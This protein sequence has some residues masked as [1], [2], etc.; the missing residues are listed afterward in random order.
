MRRLDLPPKLVQSYLTVLR[1]Q[2]YTKA[3]QAL[4]LTQPAVTQHIARLESI[5]GIPL[6]ERSRGAILP[7]QQA[8][9]LIP[10]LERLERSVGLIFDKARSVAQSWDLIIQIATPTSMVAHILAPTIADVKAAGTEVFPIIK[11]VDDY[12]V[13][14]M[15]RA[16]EVD[17]AL[18]SMTGSHSD[19]SCSFLFM[20]RPCLVCPADHALA[21]DGPVEVKDIAP[22][23]LIRPPEG[24][25][26][27]RMIKDFE[28]TYQIEFTFSAEASR[29]MTMDVMV[30]AGMGVLLLPALSARLIVDP[31]LCI[32]PINT[33][34]EGR[35]CQLIRPLR[36]RPSPLATRILER[37][38]ET[39]AD[40]VSQESYFVSRDET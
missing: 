36:I 22:F 37:M 29:L 2:S 33:H 3:A 8:Q 1:M 30:R 26:S 9:T 10:D 4:S 12:R 15:V 18:T 19:L 23:P 16:G 31:A 25:A 17:F 6:I 39:V 38:R 21:E 40:L 24:T 27:N 13:Y 35:K 7:T 20:D 32:R 5:F 34:L 11:E 14:D 28:R